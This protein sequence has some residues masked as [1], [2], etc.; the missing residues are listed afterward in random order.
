MKVRALR[1][2]TLEE[3]KFCLI[4]GT[5]AQNC[6]HRLNKRLAL[7]PGELAATIG[8]SVDHRRK[9]H[10]LK[11]FQANVLG[12]KTYKQ[13]LV[14]CLPKAQAGDSAAEEVANATPLQRPLL[15]IQQGKRVS[16]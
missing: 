9:N 13:K 11:R 14:N 12:L 3:L 5:T 6:S 1:G 2:F 8:I 10:S 7:I 16:H 15:A 4:V